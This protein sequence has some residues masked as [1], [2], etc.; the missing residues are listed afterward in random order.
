VDEFRQTLLAKIEEQIAAGSIVVASVQD[1][2]EDESDEVEEAAA[3]PTKEARHNLDQDER[4]VAVFEKLEATGA[5]SKNIAKGSA[6]KS[7][8]DKKA[9]AV[10]SAAAQKE[11][12]SQKSKPAPKSPSAP[13]PPSG[14]SSKKR[15]LP[16]AEDE[17][18]DREEETGEDDFFASSSSTAS[19]APTAKR[20]EYFVEQ[21]KPYRVEDSSR[22]SWLRQIKYD[23]FF[24]GGEGKINK[25]SF[26]FRLGINGTNC[27]RSVASTSKT[28]SQARAL[29]RAVTPLQTKAP[30]RAVTLPR[31][32]ELGD[33]LLRRVPN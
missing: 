28:A 32:R 29:A 26:F 17:D 11:A 12:A 2:Q 6:A 8:V 25:S 1:H 21:A 18:G 10:A 14:S 30:T 31:I 16:T 20:Q 23:Y 7:A 33:K 15:P 22:R 4:F 19:T 24:W 9:A 5:V 13:H 3:V 27:L